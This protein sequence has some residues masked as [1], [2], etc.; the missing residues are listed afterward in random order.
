MKPKIIFRADGSPTIGLG[1]VYRSCAL[2]GILRDHFSTHFIIT[3]A[4]EALQRE[5]S[6]A[7]DGVTSL[8]AGLTP[9]EEVKLIAEH[10]YQIIVLDGY[11]FD[12]DYQR[13]LETYAGGTIVCIDDIH[14]GTYV[15][16]AVINHIGGITTHDYKAASDVVFFLGV[17]YALVNKVFL[18]A[19]PQWGNKRKLLVCLGGSDPDNNLSTILP[20]IPANTFDEV[21]VIIGSGY[22]Y[23]PW[24]D[25]FR[26][27]TSINVHQN[28]QPQEVARIMSE[29]RYAVLSPSTVSYEYLHIGGVAF[30]YQIASNQTRVK[31]FFLE[32]KLAADF[33]SLLSG[34]YDEAELMHNRGKYFDG[35]SHERLFRIFEGLAFMKECLVRQAVPEDAAITYQWANDPLARSM[36]FSKDPIPYETHITWFTNKLNDRNACYFIFEHNKTPIAQ[37]R[38]DVKDGEAV[39]SYSIS[40]SLRGKS[41]GTWILAEGIRNVKRNFKV[42]TIVG[43]VKEENV[44]SCKSFEKLKFVRENATQFPSS[45]KYVMPVSNELYHR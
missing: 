36:S 9:E 38:F 35:K 28:V 41:L 21:N 1:H 44:A 34:N 6:G 32:K 14:Q 16:D 5:I 17:A 15:A 33:S 29:C 22:R 37:I 3:D 7:V 18:E 25:E 10:A 45:F 27:G 23:R 2:A 40:S 42:R 13:L 11:K 8:P 24:L 20:A 30:L 43:Y 31:E 19:T 39:L 12:G 26:K 4:S